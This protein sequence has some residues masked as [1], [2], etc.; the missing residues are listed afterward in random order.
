MSDPENAKHEKSIYTTNS[1]KKG[2]GSI[3][4][5]HC[6]FNEMHSVT[7]FLHEYSVEDLESFPNYYAVLIAKK[8]AQGKRIKAGFVMKSTYHHKDPDFTSNLKMALFTTENLKSF[9]QSK[10]VTFLPTRF[11][12]KDSQ[13][14]TENEMVKILV[15]QAVRRGDAFGSA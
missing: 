4:M 9:S 14:M 2:G 11:E 5:L 10:V 6:L 7:H 3:L 1:I 12:L 13:P 15:E 8:T